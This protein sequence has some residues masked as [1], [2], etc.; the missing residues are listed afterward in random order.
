[1]RYGGKYYDPSY[2]GGP[3]DDQ[4]KWEEGAID[5]LFQQSSSGAGKRAAFG[6]GIILEFHPI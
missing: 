6:A 5:G 1:V 2:G 3:F 4:K